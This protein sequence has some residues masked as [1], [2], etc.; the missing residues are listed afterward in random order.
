MELCVQK[1]PE[2]H[3]D[4]VGKNPVSGNNICSWERKG[5]PWCLKESDCNAADLDL[6]SGS[7]RSPG[8]G[9]GNHSSV[10]AW[11]IPCMEEPGGLQSMDLQRVGH[12]LRD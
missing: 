12:D 3:V 8:E 4:S 6:I 7:G 2:A 1:D 5:L 11:K 10:L 9:N